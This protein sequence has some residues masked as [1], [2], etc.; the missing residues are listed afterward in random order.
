MRHFEISAIVVS[1]L[2]LCETCTVSI[3]PGSPAAMNLTLICSVLLFHYMEGC[4]TN[5]VPL[6]S[7]SLL[8]ATLNL[9][10]GS[11]FLLPVFVAGTI[12]SLF[13]SSLY[14]GYDY[15]N[16]TLSGPHRVGYKSFFSQKFKTDVSVFYPAADDGSGTK[17]VLFLPDGR[18]HIE[19]RG[20]AAHLVNRHLRHLVNIVN[21]AML[22]TRVP[23]SRDATLLGAAK[24]QPVFI[25]HGAL[26]NKMCYS[27]HAMEL[28]SLGFCVFSVTHTDRS[29]DYHSVAGR[30][31]FS[32]PSFDY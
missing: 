28:A 9:L 26:N 21:R 10:T 24:M 18:N 12:A 2:A 20:D 3:W 17:D 31:D 7:A 14:N 6:C 22:F 11:T 13:F 29:A 19:G 1:L 27:S 30:P 25:S 8:H 15:S 32:K 23:V 5:M 4:R 16:L